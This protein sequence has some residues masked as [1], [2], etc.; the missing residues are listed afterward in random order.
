MEPLK[1]L[2]EAMAY[3][4]SNL[5]GEIDFR[6]VE[7]LAG[8]SEYHFRRMFSFLAGMSLSEYIRLR[9]LSQAAMD[10]RESPIRVIDV[11]VKYGYDS[12]DAFARAFQ[13]LHGIPPSEARADGVALKA[14]PPMSFQLSIQGGTKMDYRIVEKDAFYV[15][16]ITRRVTLVYE[17]VNPQIAAMWESLTPDDFNALK[18]LSDVEP[19]GLISASV[20]FEEGRAEGTQ[21][22]HYIGVASTQPHTDQWQSLA[23]PA[24]M[25][26][27]FTAR[28][29]F[30]DALQKVWGQI[31][32][33]WFPMSEYQV[34]AG[35]EM[36]WNAGKDTTAPD[37]HSEI[38]IPIVR[39]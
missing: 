19:K 8:C 34:S 1:Q 13:A 33:E 35:P 11:A 32:A 15:V 10:L 6:R 25:W 16:G 12:P 36:L 28:G 3:I 38:W 26:G 27:V 5:A 31:Y 23:V 24:S 18:G 37:F 2:N 21:L 14:V 4:E 9:R 7:Q 20:N 22:D 30:P 29:P 17:G 39:K